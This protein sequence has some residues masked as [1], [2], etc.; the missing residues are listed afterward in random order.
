[1]STPNPG[2]TDEFPAA[3][4]F[5]VPPPDPYSTLPQVDLAGATHRGLV[6]ANNEDCYLVG[7]VE[8]ALQV[9]ATNLPPEYGA[10]RTEEVAYGMIECY[11]MGGLGGGEAARRAGTDH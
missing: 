9:V 8:R 6:R 4:N 10:S 11:G 5:H 1:M 2:D 7:R 3:L